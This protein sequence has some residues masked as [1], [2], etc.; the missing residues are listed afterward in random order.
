MPYS[1]L[2]VV[3]SLIPT[4][5]GF[6]GYFPFN[7]LTIKDIVAAATLYMVLLG[8]WASVH[9]ELMP[10]LTHKILLFKILKNFYQ[11]ALQEGLSYP[12][13]T[14]KIQK[15]PLPTP[16]ITLDDPDH[17]HCFLL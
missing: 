11:I 5:D 1:V 9:I 15:R 12:Y 6:I 4:T 2:M 10:V 3:Y 7:F 13:S 8:L 17:F 16:L 14:T